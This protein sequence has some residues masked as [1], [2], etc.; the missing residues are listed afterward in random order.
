M[1]PRQPH[2]TFQTSRFKYSPP[3][4]SHVNVN[5]VRGRT[6]NE[7]TQKA[8]L[9]LTVGQVGPEIPLSIGSKLELFLRASF[10]AKFPFTSP[11]IHAFVRVCIYTCLFTIY[12]VHAEGFA[13]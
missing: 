2:V 10:F 11:Y 8:K 9:S 4:L 7:S 13:L 3:Q 12:N 6:G 5:R 1:V